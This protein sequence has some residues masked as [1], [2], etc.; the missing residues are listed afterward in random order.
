MPDFFPFSKCFFLFPFIPA[1][2]DSAASAA[3]VSEPASADPKFDDLKFDS[4]MSDQNLLAKSKNIKFSF[5]FKRSFVRSLDN[6]SIVS[7]VAPKLSFDLSGSGI[8]PFFS[9]N[10]KL[11]FVLKDPSFDRSSF[12]QYFKNVQIVYPDSKHKSFQAFCFF[13][14]ISSFSLGNKSWKVSFEEV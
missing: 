3:S 6:S 7:N 11:I 2:L 12:K 4:L 8:A 5:D 14:F 9:Q 13:V 1:D 10:Q